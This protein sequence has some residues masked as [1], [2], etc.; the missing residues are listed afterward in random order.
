VYQPAPEKLNLTSEWCV[1][2]TSRM[3]TEILFVCGTRAD[4][5][6]TDRSDHLFPKE[7]V[8]QDHGEAK[9]I[10]SQ[11]LQWLNAGPSADIHSIDAW[12]EGTTL[13][14]FKTEAFAR[15]LD[16]PDFDQ[17]KML[18]TLLGYPAAAIT[19]EEY[20]E[21][22]Y[23]A[24]K[25]SFPS[26]DIKRALQFQGREGKLAEYAK[27]LGEVFQG[28]R[29]DKVRQLQRRQAFTGIANPRGQTWG[30]LA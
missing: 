6:L 11:Y 22:M 2:M 28:L 17:W 3:F 7:H 27:Y 19:P 13:K 8:F 4:W 10:C 14:L 12:K 1:T 9:S 23:M 15:K 5:L 20:A 30:A 16:F 18:R 25:R 29:D 21:S 26:S 24:V